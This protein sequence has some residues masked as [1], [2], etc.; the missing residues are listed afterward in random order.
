MPRHW[1]H[2]PRYTVDMGAHTFP[3][4]KF[5]RVAESLVERGVLSSAFRVE[6]GDPSR[7]D[8]LLVHTPSW[9]ERV[10]DGKM[11]LDD[12][13]R[14]EL[15]WSKK[16]AEAHALAVSGT[17]LAAREALERGLGI[18]VG[19]GAH[20][21]FPD[22]G[23]GFCL[24]NDLAVAAERLR[25]GGLAKSVLVVDLDVHQ[26]NGTAAIFRDRLDVC[27]FSMHQEEGY[28]EKRERGTVD[29]ELPAGATDEDYLDVLTKR[30]PA[31]LDA[32]RPD[33]VLY[34]AGVDVHERDLLGSLKLTSGGIAARDRFV[35]EACF[36][37]AIPVGVTLGGGYSPSLE[38]TVLLHVQTVREALAVFS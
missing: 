2:S 26:G 34:Q 27:T 37:R 35:F 13:L 28:P 1:F 4:V 38:E 11:T 17:M 16:L 9:V 36:R 15:P 7:D 31:A 22:H 3:T 33:L 19:G 24:L 10:L 14:A 8:L 23:E 20:H 6:P 30:L 25:R 18:H 32:H 5:Q 12:E 21:A 29:I